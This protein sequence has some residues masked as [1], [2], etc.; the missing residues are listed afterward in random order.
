[1]FVSLFL[2]AVKNSVWYYCFNGNKNLFDP[3]Q[4][5]TV[6]LFRNEFLRLRLRGPLYA[7]RS[8]MALVKNN[9]SCLQ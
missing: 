4:L 6:Q 5:A 1:M 2:A 8:Y 9:F 7:L 3:I